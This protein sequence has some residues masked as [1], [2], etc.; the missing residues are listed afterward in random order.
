[1]K[2]PFFNGYAIDSYD[3]ILL[4][5]VDGSSNEFDK[6]SDEC[7][8]LDKL[9]YLDIDVEKELKKDKKLLMPYHGSVIDSDFEYM[10]IE[11]CH[12]LLQDFQELE[13]QH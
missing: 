6:S 3:D 5:L 11:L 12:T 1:M 4:K 13:N 9:R 7:H 10:E 2:E 8:I